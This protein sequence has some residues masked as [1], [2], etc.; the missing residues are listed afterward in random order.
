MSCKNSGRTGRCRPFWASLLLSALPVA[1]HGEELAPT[2]V[3]VVT[4]TREGQL[5]SET[6]ASVSVLGGAEV[7]AV[8]PAHPSEIL[9]RIPGVAVAATNGE[10]HM[11]GIRQPIGT[12]PVYLYLEDGVPTRATGF[13]NHNALYE[14]NV[15]AAGSIEVTRGPGTALQGSDAIGGI[16]NVLT[17]APSATPEAM[18]TLEGGSFGW[19]RGLASGS[20]TWGELGVRGD[21]NITHSDGWRDRSA[22]DRRSATLRADKALAGDG[23]LKL[24]VSA[25]DIDQQTGAASYL[26]AADYAANPTRNVNPIAFRKVQAVRTTIDWEQPVG[27]ALVS[28]TP[29]MRYDRMQ[30][31]PT[32]MLSYD[33]VIYTTGNWSGGLMAKYRLDLEPWR[34]RIVTGIDL[35]YSPGWHDED[36]I[37]ALRSGQVY[38]SYSRT[39]ALY[40][41]DVTFLQASPYLHVETSPLEPLRLSAGLRFDAQRFDYRNRLAAGAFATTTP[42]GSATYF[43]PASQ[44]RNFTHAGPSAGATWRFGPAL[45]A[46]FAYKQSF[47]S[48]SE[49]QLF[50]QGANLDT[51][52]L[53]PVRVDSYEVGLRGALEPAVTWELSVYRMDKR[54]DILTTN[55]GTGPTSTNNGRTR[56]Q[57]VEG[58]LAWSFL[59]GWRLDAVM[60][61]A[62]HTYRRWVTRVGSATVD[63]SGNQ[64]PMAPHWV[65]NLTLEWKPGFIEGLRLEGE[66]S[67]LGR[68]RMDDANQ[69]SYPGHHLFNLRASYAL[70]GGFELFGRVMNIADRRWA[71]SSQVS[72]GQEQFAPGLP[73]T[74]YAGVT[75]TF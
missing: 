45:N 52:H 65:S 36:R 32:F 4:A 7:D 27:P 67:W 15:P 20:G 37:A 48:P 66:W 2:E 47:R 57:G 62:D 44:R 6:P 1:G 3:I 74:V 72:N 70:G 51:V 63:Y 9:G 21:V 46:F 16:I 38:V 56:H 22:Y 53:K 54:D 61:Y 25:T 73:R 5:R 69:H 18:L 13:F 19:L 33:P 64:I 41:Y 23:R 39:Q 14:V 31:L 10:G 60:S 12:S 40:H 55:T 29:Y 58:G 24:V 28:L 43:R 17:R 59:P 11:T 71:T 42:F 49:G 34:T 8:K 26:S 35:D 30:L 50:R 75:K 68:Y